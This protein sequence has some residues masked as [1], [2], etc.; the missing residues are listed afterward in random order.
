[1]I[2]RLSRTDVKKGKEYTL[3]LRNS[4]KERIKNS[5]ILNEDNHS[6]D[7]KLEERLQLANN[8]IEE[9]IELNY[10]SKHNKNKICIS[11]IL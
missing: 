1:M 8:V 11:D 4:I 5:S 9:A 2:P 6:N 3:Y 7:E 10:H